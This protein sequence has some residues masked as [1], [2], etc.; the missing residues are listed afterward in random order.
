MRT[1]A[2]FPNADRR[3]DSQLARDVTPN[4]DGSFTVHDR[5]QFQNPYGGIIAHTYVCTVRYL[6]ESQ[7]QLISLRMS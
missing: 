5:F 4:P 2:A 6:G 7:A 3:S 1:A